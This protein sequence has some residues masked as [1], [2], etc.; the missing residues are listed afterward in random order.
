MITSSKRIGF[1]PSDLGALD[2]LSWI[3]VDILA[4]VI[5]ELAGI[6]QKP[7]DLPSGKS[8]HGANTK[9]EYKSHATVYH[10][11]NPHSI[12]WA[13]LV[14]TVAEALHI[15]S[16]K[17]VP[18]AEW[19]SALR[20]SAEGN[21]DPEANTGLKL[22]DYFESLGGVEDGQ[23]VMP[24]LATEL[25]KRQSETLAALDPVGPEWMKLWLKQWAL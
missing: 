18:W 19:V 11:T 9:P 2:N 3:P 21:E 20:S 25:T 22:L 5:L 15:S 17:I 24:T 4:D 14:P 10:A 16:D 23:G 6:I 13:E 12:R 1:L 8:V 7:E